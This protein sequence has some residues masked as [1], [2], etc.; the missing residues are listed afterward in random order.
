MIL[1]AISSLV[2]C[3][4]PL[5]WGDC[6]CSWPCR[7]VDPIFYPIQAFHSLLASISWSCH[8]LAPWEP[9]SPS[10]A[11]WTHEFCCCPGLALLHRRLDILYAC[12]DIDSTDPWT[13]SILFDGVPSGPCGSQPLARADFHFFD[14]VYLAF[15]LVWCFLE[16]SSSL[17][18]C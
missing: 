17:G 12:Q 16:C 8:W 2:L 10:P 13:P 3:L 18:D 15:H 9:G 4:P 7:I 11:N 6:V 5:C 1:I 14:G